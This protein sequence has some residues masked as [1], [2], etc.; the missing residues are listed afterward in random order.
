MRQQR[1]AIGPLL[2]EHQ[3]QRIFA[4]EMH[5]VRDASGLPAGAMDMFEAQFANLAERIFASRHAAGH[6]DHRVLPFSFSPIVMEL[7]RRC[8]QSRSVAAASA[9]ARHV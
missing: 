1:G 6:Y 2:D 8:W 7:N 9:S 5:G 4:I 3:P